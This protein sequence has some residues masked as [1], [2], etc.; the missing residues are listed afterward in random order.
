MMTV[1]SIILLNFQQIFF[2]ISLS[3]N[4]LYFQP[5]SW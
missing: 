4:T 5:K 3:V 2:G 1:F